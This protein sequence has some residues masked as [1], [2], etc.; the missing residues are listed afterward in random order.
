MDKTRKDE[1]SIDTVARLMKEERY[2]LH[3]GLIENGQSK[4]GS[5]QM[6]VIVETN[7]NTET[8]RE[9]LSGLL[10]QLERG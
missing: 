9:L 10:A 2:G 1:Y 4:S 8:I 6:G 5:P 7:L 3:I